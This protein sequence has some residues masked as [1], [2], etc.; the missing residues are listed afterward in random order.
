MTE[1]KPDNTYYLLALLKVDY[2]KEKKIDKMMPGTTEQKVQ[3]KE[4]MDVT[5]DEL[6][7]MPS[8]TKLTDADNIKTALIS[9]ARPI[10]REKLT[11]LKKDKSLIDALDPV[12]TAETI[13]KFSGGKRNNGGTRRKRKKDAK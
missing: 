2:Y 5:V 1:K 8:A 12:G 6:F 7:S 13:F 11:E 4:R 10:P 3:E 9:V